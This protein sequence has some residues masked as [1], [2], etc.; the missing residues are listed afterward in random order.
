M[1]KFIRPLLFTQDPETAH[2]RVTRV[3]AT[4]AASPLRGLVNNM[5]A[6]HDSMLHTEVAGI[7]FTNPIGIA[8]GFDKHARFI[9]LLAMLGF[10]HVEVGSITAQPRDGNPRPRL[11]RLP[12]DAAL[13]NRMGLNNEGAD[14]IAKKLHGKTFPIPYGM[15][16]TK[17]HDPEILGNRAI[18]DFVYSFKKLYAFGS[19]MTINVS[20]PNTAEGKTFEDPQTLNELLNALKEAETGFVKKKPLFVKCSPDIALTELERIVEVCEKH[21]IDGYVMSNTSAKR[22]QL[23]T[24]TIRLEKIGKGGLSGKPIRERSTKSI[25]HLYRMTKKP[26]IGVGGIFTATDAYEKIRAGAAL[27]QIYTGMIYEGPGIAKTI[28][29][30]L[31]QLLKRDGFSSVTEAV[32]TAA[33]KH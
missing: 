20:C 32:G 30:R 4:V 6:Y 3:A 14:A 13:I 7:S 29:Q 1:Y 26:I 12:E 27:V 25:A 17:T 21:A 18:E 8:A 19:Y 24:S 31:V 2:E 5:F 16:I 10:G 22:D 15:N 28:N 23:K 9:D 11:F 33:D